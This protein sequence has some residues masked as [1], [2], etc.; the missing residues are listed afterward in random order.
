MFPSNASLNIDG[1]P[2][3]ISEGY[4]NYSVVPGYHTV[5]I[6]ENGYRTYYENVTT[7]SGKVISIQVNLKSDNSISNG[8]DMIYY[9][10]A[11]SGIVIIS[12][13]GYFVW[14][15]KK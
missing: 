1:N 10:T 9:G 11:A 8:N 5:R 15:R 14:R 6:F 12:M 3:T 13:A 7:Q 4:F 2:V